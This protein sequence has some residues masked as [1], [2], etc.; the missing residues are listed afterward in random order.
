L[1]A[2]FIS[3]VLPALLAPKIRMS[4]EY[5]SESENPTISPSPSRRPPFFFSLGSKDKYIPPYL[6][7]VG[8]LI[9]L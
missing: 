6:V 8:I 5:P 7:G 4:G 9:K 2:T 1:E 3:G